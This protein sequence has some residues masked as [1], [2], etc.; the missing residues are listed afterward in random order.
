M[1]KMFLRF[2]RG[3]EIRGKWHKI[4]A[5]K[6]NCPFCF[7]FLEPR[8]DE[9]DVEVAGFAGGSIKLSD[10]QGVLTLGNLSQKY[11]D[12]PDLRG[13]LANAE[14]DAN[15][16]KPFTECDKLLLI[17]S[18]IYSE[19]FEVKGERMRQVKTKFYLCRKKNIS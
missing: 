7:F 4:V 18:V 11:I 2:R 14:L 13:I 9:F 12:D 1:V 6:L 15:K 8:N 5:L 3:R 16:M 19:K 17:T 10:D